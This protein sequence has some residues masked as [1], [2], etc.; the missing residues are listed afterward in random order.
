LL[1]ATKSFLLGETLATA[2]AACRPNTELTTI[3]AG[4]WIHREAPDAYVEA[5]RGFWR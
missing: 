5:V 4:H 1:R 3:D 2:M